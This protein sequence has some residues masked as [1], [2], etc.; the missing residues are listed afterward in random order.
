MSSTQGKITQEDL[1]QFLKLLVEACG[2]LVIDADE[3]FIRNKNNEKL[4]KLKDSNDKESPIKI[5]H[6]NRIPGDYY[7]LNLFKETSAPNEV[8]NWFFNNLEER[9]GMVIMLIMNGIM[10]L[11]MAKD[12]EDKWIELT[13][14]IRIS[15]KVKPDDKVKDEIRSIDLSDL[16][17]IYYDPDMK[18]AEIQCN[19]FEEDV[20]SK[21]SKF[22]KKTWEFI[23]AVF[24]AL[25]ECGPDDI[26]KIFEYKTL[27]I[28][29]RRCE[30]YIVLAFRFFKKLEEVCK[31]LQIETVDLEAYEEHLRYI[32][33]Y[34]KMVMWDDGVKSKPMKEV[35][36]PWEEQRQAEKEYTPQKSSGVPDY[37]SSYNQSSSYR[38]VSRG[39]PNVEVG[40][41][42]RLHVRERGRVPGY[43]GDS[44][45]DY[46]GRRSSNVPDYE[47]RRHNSGNG[48]SIF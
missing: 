25:F 47:G 12:A 30:A 21:Y 37:G 17:S 20:K 3:F 42:G 23:T 14:V 40:G 10:N 18:E 19:L 44:L 38:E 33:K 1:T 9:M 2:V 31:V 43:G 5:Y 7:L 41:D 13:K 26:S 22:K 45:P 34:Q 27:T 11:M 16:I 39:V 48:I 36:L 32:E 4:I 15:E 24:E 8:Q 29:A 35:S 28:G 6:N 46:G